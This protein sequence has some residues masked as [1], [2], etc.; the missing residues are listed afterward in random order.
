MISPTL[1]SPLPLSSGFVGPG[2]QPGEADEAVLDF[3]SLPKAMAAYAPPSLPEPDRVARLGPA[4]GLLAALQSALAA[5]R[6][7]DPPPRFDLTQLDPTNREMLDQ[8]LGEGEVS[9]RLLAMPGSAPGGDIQETRLAGLWWVREQD[10]SGRVGREYL[11]IA[12]L[13]AL[14]RDR[15][16][17]GAL[18]Q[19]SLPNPLPP[20]VMNSPGV[21]AE[22]NGHAARFPDR[23]SPHLVN[24]TLLPQ[25]PEDLILLDQVLAPGTLTLVSRGY[26]TCR[27]T[28]TALRHCWRVRHF[29][30]E[31]RLILDSLEVAAAPLAVLAAQEDIS[32]SAVHLG[33]ILTALRG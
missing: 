26:G 19:V 32:D 24:L 4:L 6:L 7:G 3:P 31:E 30:S 10:A 15:D 33:E 9:G 18:D 28:A 27:V 22:V 17:A 14:V 8:T 12:D 1:V 25:T 23:R 21:L 20:G 5:Y 29:N 16:F 11:E 2:S 13:P